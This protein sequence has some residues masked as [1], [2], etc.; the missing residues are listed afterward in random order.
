MVKTIYPFEDIFLKLI[1]IW[2]DHAH[3]E[4]DDG[5]SAEEHKT[6]EEYQGEALADLITF[7]NQ[8]LRILFRLATLVFF[9]LIL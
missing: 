7:L 3:Q 4:V 9:I 1:N 6:K 2:D 5:G 8:E